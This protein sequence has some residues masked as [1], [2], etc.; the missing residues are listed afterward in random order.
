M[1]TSLSRQ[2]ALINE[3]EEYAYRYSRL[4]SHSQYLLFD[5]PARPGSLSVKWSGFQTGLRFASGKQEAVLQRLPVPDRREAA[6]ARRLDLGPRAA[7]VGPRYVRVQRKGGSLG[8]RIKTN[9]SGY[10][11]KSTAARATTGSEHMTGTESTSAP[12]APRARSD[13][14]RSG[15]C[16]SGG[17]G[18]RVARRPTA[19]F[20]AIYHRTVRTWQSN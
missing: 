16:T 8:P 1:S 20:S 12:A 6:P 5:D 13:S 11:G 14:A 3:K 4:K 10:F 2:A 18:A 15:P 19:G 7:G 9:W 17:V